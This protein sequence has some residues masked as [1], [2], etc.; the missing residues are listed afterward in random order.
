MFEILA[1][2]ASVNPP[3]WVGW[4]MVALALITPILV[5]TLTKK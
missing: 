2:S 5:N 3:G 4:L 1:E